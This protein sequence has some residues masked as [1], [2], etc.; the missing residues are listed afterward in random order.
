MKL[1]SL[2]RFKNSAV[3]VVYLDHN[4]KRDVEV[5]VIEEIR[6]D[7][8]TLLSNKKIVNIPINQINSIE[9]LPE[10]WKERWAKDGG[11]GEDTFSPA[12]FLMTAL[13]KLLKNPQERERLLPVLEKI[14]ELEIGDSDLKRLIKRELKKPLESNRKSNEEI[15]G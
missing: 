1:S 8:I 9:K 6:K 4:Q 10:K 3:E 11:E 14:K 13:E 5:G 12:N 7:R 15:G 2:N